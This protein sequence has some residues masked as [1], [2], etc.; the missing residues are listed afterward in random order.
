MPE[1][2]A[3]DA[4]VSP[5]RTKTEQKAVREAT[6]KVYLRNVRINSIPLSYTVGPTSE[7]SYMD[8]ESLHDNIRMSNV[9]KRP[10]LGLT[11]LATGTKSQTLTKLFS[12][13]HVFSQSRVV[14]VDNNSRGNTNGS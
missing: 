3:T 6:R 10:V 5:A 1:V 7:I 2:A 12:N 8:E 13:I 9:S 14:H 4:V 11:A